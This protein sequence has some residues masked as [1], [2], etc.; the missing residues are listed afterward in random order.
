M[1]NNE[2]KRFDN[3]LGYRG[4]NRNS[5]LSI[6]REKDVTRAYG[7][8]I[9]ICTTITFRSSSARTEILCIGPENL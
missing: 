9:I 3:G 2:T 8:N 6:R 5:R 4:R 7:P 1:D